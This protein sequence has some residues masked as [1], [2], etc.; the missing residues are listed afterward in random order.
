MTKSDS[1]LPG[2]L[3]Q[4]PESV[5]NWHSPEHV[6]L[7]LPQ[8]E[9]LSARWSPQDTTPKVNVQASHR[10]NSVT[11][12]SQQRDMV[13]ARKVVLRRWFALINSS[14]PPWDKTFAKI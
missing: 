9:Q 10:L 4:K 12:L 5:S 6:A 13:R 2:F 8:A 14:A 7:V 3:S 11:A 1:D